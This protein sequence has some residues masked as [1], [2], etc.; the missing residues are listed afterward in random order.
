V[1]EGRVINPPTDFMH[2][3]ESPHSNVISPLDSQ[4]FQIRPHGPSTAPPTYVKSTT[5]FNFSPNT[6]PDLHSHSSNTTWLPKRRKDIATAA[7]Q[8]EASHVV[9][10]STLV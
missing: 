5:R 2:S 6:H 10:D 7:V 8:T 9:G 3:S 4:R 1:W